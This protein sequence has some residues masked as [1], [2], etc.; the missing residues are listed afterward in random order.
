MTYVKPSVDTKMFL[1]LCGCPRSGTTALWRVLVGDSRIRMGVERYEQLFH[2]TDPLRQEVFSAERFFDLRAGDTFYSSLDDFDAYYAA[3]RVG[4]DESIYFGDKIPKMYEYL[5]KVHRDFPGCKIIF[6]FR[7]IFDVAASYKVRQL[8]IHDSWYMDVSTAI[9]DWNRSFKNAESYKGKLHLVDYEQFFIRGVGLE[10]LYDFLEL[11][12]TEEALE[13]YRLHL[14]QSS[15]LEERRTRSLTALE[16]KEICET[17][18]FDAYR[19][20]CAQAA[21]SLNSSR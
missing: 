21:S 19:R 1:F 18:D 20:F 12:V 16:I 3:A 6:I 17:A 13:T 8:D 10:K 15:Q 5:D 9:I 4:Y 14:A 11:D 2:K 7:N